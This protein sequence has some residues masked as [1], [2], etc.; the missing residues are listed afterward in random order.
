MTTFGDIIINTQTALSMSSGLSV[1]TYAQPKLAL[2]LQDAFDFFFEKYWWRQYRRTSA[3][4]FNATTGIIT[5]DLSALVLKPEDLQ[6]VWIDNY[7]S[8]LPLTP[9]DA[10]VN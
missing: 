1:Q 9:M 8:P 10:N 5:T 6:F 4:T 7:R 2:A 3:V